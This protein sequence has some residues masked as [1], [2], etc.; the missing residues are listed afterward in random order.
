MSIENRS[1]YPNNRLPVAVDLL[2]E[3]IRLVLLLPDIEAV[4]KRAAKL[5]CPIY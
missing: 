1:A 3:E 2:P 5:G 4:A